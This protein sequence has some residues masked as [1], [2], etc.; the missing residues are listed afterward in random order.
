VAKYV[1]NESVVLKPNPWYYRV[2]SKGQRLPYL[3]E[4]IWVVVP[5]QNAEVI[6]FKAGE[7]DGIYLR[8]ED[9]ESIKAGEAEGNYTVTELGSEYGSNFLFFNLN[10]GKDAKGKPYVDPVKASWFQNRQFRLAVAHAIDR[11]SIV[12][13]VFHGLAWP[14]YGVIPDVNKVWHNPNITKYPYDLDKARQ[15]LADAGFKDK[16]GDGIL[17]DPAGHKVS[18]RLFTNTSTKERIA[19][20]TLVA[21]DLKKIGLDAQFQPLEFNSLTTAVQK[22]YDFDAVMLGLSGG[23]PPDPVMASGTLKSSGGTHFWWANQSKPGTPWEAEIDSLY[24]AQLSLK[25]DAERKPYIDRIQQIMA[26]EVPAIYTVSRKGYVA[27]RN[28]VKNARPSIFRPYVVWNAEELWVDPKAGSDR[29][30]K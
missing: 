27:I 26:D 5:D 19:A 29:A 2:D 25:T 13:N 21:E 17:E 15:I 6:K 9:Y 11:E 23:N 18:F 7:T 1:P 14:Q 8:P 16:N 3:D 12:R 30:S 10:T 20:C 24:D 22:T 28:R 4:L